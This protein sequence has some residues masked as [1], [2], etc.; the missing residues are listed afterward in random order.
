MK[1]YYKF[2]FTI[3]NPIGI[4]Q[5]KWR[6]RY[7]YKKWE[8]DTAIIKIYAK[9]SKFGKVYWE[10]VLLE[11]LAYSRLGEQVSEVE[12]RDRCEIRGFDSE[13]R[14]Y[15]RTI[16]REIGLGKRL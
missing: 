6:K 14:K 16:L 1:Q 2:S 7:I 9:D 12:L 5:N 8:D 13:M 4:L 15:I 3:P 11:I 10:H